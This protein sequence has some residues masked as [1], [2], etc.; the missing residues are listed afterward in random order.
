VEVF[1][2]ASTQVKMEIFVV[3]KYIYCDMITWSIARQRLNEQLF[4]TTDMHATIEELSE[5]VTLELVSCEAVRMSPEED[6]VEICYQAT[7]DEDIAN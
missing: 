4:A 7:T 1:N 5:T 2:L 3:N 6:I